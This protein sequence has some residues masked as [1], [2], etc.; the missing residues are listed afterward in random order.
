MNR[1]IL[2]SL[3]D[4]TLIDERGKATKTL[5]LRFGK[6]RVFVLSVLLGVSVGALLCVMHPAQSLDLS[7]RARAW[8][9]TTAD[10]LR[11]TI[12]VPLR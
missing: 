1:T 10:Q 2:L 4:V 3:S 9:R 12:D 5:T 7:L 6:L 11:A 8:L